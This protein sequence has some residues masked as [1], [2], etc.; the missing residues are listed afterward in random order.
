MGMITWSE[1]YRM[2]VPEL[3]EDHRQLFQISEQILKRVKTRG[4]EAP[5]RM[6]VLREGLN[7]LHGYFA[8]HA[9]RE[10]SYM[11]RIGYP[12]YALHK[13]QHEDFQNNQ[14]AKYQKI[15]DSGVCSQED[16]WEFVGSGIGW[17]LEHIATADLAI[18]GKGVLSGP[19]KADV[20]K[21]ALEREIN[22]LLAAT[23]NIEANA[24]IISTQYAG[25]PFGR[26]VCQRFVYR[27][28][29]Q[30]STVISGI[31]RSF[32]LSVAKMLYGDHVEDEMDLV[33]STV[34]E[35]SAQFWITLSR[36]LTGNYEKI[37]ILE[38]HFL[39][40]QSLSDELRNLHPVVSILFTSDLGKFFISS[41]SE[42]MA[43]IC[44]ISA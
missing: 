14:L 13:M 41:D 35:F 3:D 39:L 33:L 21:T 5:M 34:E 16:V 40:A 37:D 2:G 10:E 8:H 17:L 24:K 26:A 22:L 19:P 38:N 4:D 1:T 15:A 11:R 32:L 9:A 23:L 6:F 12:G 44:K 30:A 28:G 18:V 7:Y 20:N 43:N 36:Q 29:E 25:E 27:R 31:E 42:R